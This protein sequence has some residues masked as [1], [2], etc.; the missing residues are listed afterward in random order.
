ML[1]PVDRETQ[2]NSQ[3]FDLLKVL[4]HCGSLYPPLEG[5][6]K[7][8]RT[9][10]AWAHIHRA[11]KVGFWEDPLPN[12]DFSGDASQAIADVCREAK[13]LGMDLDYVVARSLHTLPEG[14]VGFGQG[15]EARAYLFCHISSI[16]ACGPDVFL[17]HRSPRAEHL[18]NGLKNLHQ[19]PY[20][21]HTKLETVFLEQM[22]PILESFPLPPAVTDSFSQPRTND[23]SKPAP[24]SR[25]EGLPSFWLFAVDLCAGRTKRTA[26]SVWNLLGPLL[27][28]ACDHYGRL[29]VSPAPTQP[30]S[31]TPVPLM[32]IVGLLIAGNCSMEL[33][34]DPMDDDLLARRLQGVQ[35]GSILAEQQTENQV[36]P[37]PT[38]AIPLTVAQ[39]QQPMTSHRGVRAQP[40]SKDDQTRPQSPERFPPL[41]LTHLGW[42]LSVRLPDVDALLRSWPDSFLCRTWNDS[43]LRPL[44]ASFKQRFCRLDPLLY[45]ASIKTISGTMVDIYK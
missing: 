10:R 25:V 33:T 24:D 23:P 28:Q 22:C 6:N 18:L 2:F 31:K 3:D 45:K 7:D 19:L 8:M 20:P 39:A 26:R 13:D 11:P 27:P 40:M 29:T 12:K 34:S 42:M 21:L 36:Q 5:P 17:F 37:Q 43:A 44:L 41:G 30:S 35:V 16:Y 1:D 14:V 9:A 15:P 4:I 32:T 38:T